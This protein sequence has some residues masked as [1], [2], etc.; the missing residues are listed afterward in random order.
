MLKIKNTEN[1]FYVFNM[2]T[3]Y[4]VIFLLSKTLYVDKR[5]KNI[6]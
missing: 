6:V 4:V 3:I 1:R 5:S 2:T